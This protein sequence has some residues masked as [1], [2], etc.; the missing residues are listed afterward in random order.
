M[1]Q[2]VIFCEVIDNFG[3]IG[4]VYRLARNLDENYFNVIVVT[5]D[6]VKLA[7]INHGASSK[8]NFQIVENI[9][10]ISASVLYKYQNMISR[11]D[12]VIEAFGCKISGDILEYFQQEVLIIN[13]EYLNTEKWAC[14]LHLNKSFTP[15]GQKYFFM[16]SLYK[17]S[18]G[19]LFDALNVKKGSCWKLE[20]ILKK[21][22]VSLK[23]SQLKAKKYGEKPLKK[24]LIFSYF[25]E[26]SEFYKTLKYDINSEYIL[27]LC[28]EKTQKSIKDLGVE[29]GNDENV[30][31]I[32]MP[33]M[34]QLDFD[35]LVSQ[36]DL[37]FIRGEDSF[38]RA[39]IAGKPFLWQA[40]KQEDN[41]Q[42][43]KIKSLLAIISNFMDSD[44]F[45]KYS[46]LLIKFNLNKGE[47]ILRDEYQW[48][49]ENLSE[50]EKSFKFFSEY[51]VKN[52]N[53]VYNLISFITSKQI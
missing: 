42:I 7:T 34:S 44:V 26:F 23:P 50:I 21:Y 16:P 19:V 8:K 32:F 37:N 14:D 11:T 24:I 43:E 10:Y 6:L 12:V 47:G 27:I 4:V 52:C 36:V 2:V 13:I 51:V 49:I 39:V 46:Q 41:Y 15:I 17:E 31:S 20:N 9:T 1:K 18:G 33:V 38:V 29:Q 5:N 45:E 30:F 35:A 3:D 28:G 48:F 53:L 25:Q 22:G 40:Y